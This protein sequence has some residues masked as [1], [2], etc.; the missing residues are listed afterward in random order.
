M[1]R[2]SGAGPGL[3]GRPDFN[4]AGKSDY[5]VIR[6]LLAK[7]V[8][9]A[10]R[11]IAERGIVEEGS[12]FLVRFITQVAGWF[13]LVVTQ[14]AAAQTIPVIGAVGGQPLIM[15]LS[16]TSNQWPA[17]I[18]PSA[19]LSESTGKRLFL[20]LTRRFGETS[21]HHPDQEG[22]EPYPADCAT[23]NDCRIF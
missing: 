3:A 21:N 18:L 6:G 4:A 14:K 9:E 5:F 16:T 11:F 2:A 12:P 19:G 10:A 13:G 20:L 23:Y 1:T 17:A 15:H 8:T 22:Q 7:S